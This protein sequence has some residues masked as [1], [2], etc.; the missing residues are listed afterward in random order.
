MEMALFGE[1]ADTRTRIRFELDS[2]YQGKDGFEMVQRA[3]AA[4]RPYAMAFMDIRMPPGWDG[5]ETMSLT[6]IDP[7]LLS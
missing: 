7:P 6:G 2:A 3:V 4:G 1:S 5:I